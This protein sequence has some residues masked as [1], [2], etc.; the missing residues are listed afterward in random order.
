MNSSTIAVIVVIVL[1]I[2]VLYI[3]TF[4]KW[5]RRKKRKIHEYE[6]I[7]YKKMYNRK[8]NDTEEE[9]DEEN[10]LPK[11][12]ISRDDLVSLVQNEIHGEKKKDKSEK[13]HFTF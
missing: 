4:I 9:S 1:F 6:T 7:K 3:Y 8:Y 13:F 12:Y 11:D 5:R 2:G 10:T